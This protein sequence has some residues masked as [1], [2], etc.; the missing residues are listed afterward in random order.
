VYFFSTPTDNEGF[1]LPTKVFSLHYIAH[2]QMGPYGSF[3]C[4]DFTGNSKRG[5]CRDSKHSLFDRKVFVDY[6]ISS[7]NN[8]ALCRTLFLLLLSMFFSVLWSVYLIIVRRLV[9]S[10]NNQSTLSLSLSL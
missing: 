5:V 7:D 1:F 10:E 2:V 3:A 6:I 8:N 9:A 4:C